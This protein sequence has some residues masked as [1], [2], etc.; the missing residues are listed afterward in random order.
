MELVS[1]LAMMAGNGEENSIMSK[2]SKSELQAAL[3]SLTS[4]NNRAKKARDK[5]F[6]HC[7]VVYGFTPLDVNNDQFIDACD[8]GCGES[9]G[10]TS[11]EFEASMLHANWT[12]TAGR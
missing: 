5:I 1:L 8:G 7:E 10:M 6:A 3:D 12:H 2:L 4:A 11:V 9:H